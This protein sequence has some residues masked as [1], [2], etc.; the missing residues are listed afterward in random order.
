MTGEKQPQDGSDATRLTVSYAING[1]V[2]SREVDPS[3]SLLD[4]L[5]A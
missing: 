3:E 1:D 4:D 5:R 2:S